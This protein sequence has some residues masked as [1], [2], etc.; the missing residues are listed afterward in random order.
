MFKESKLVI[1]DAKNGKD[2]TTDDLVSH[3]KQ[4]PAVEKVQSFGAF[5]RCM[6]YLVKFRPPIHYNQVFR[7]FEPNSFL[8][9]DFPIVFE[10]NPSHYDDFVQLQFFLPLSSN[11]LYCR[12]KDLTRPLGAFEIKMLNLL[13]IHQAK[14]RVCGPSLEILTDCVDTYRKF[15]KRDIELF[16]K[17]HLFG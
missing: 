9:G 5:N 7:E 16:H 14:V 11:K 17:A 3:Y 2:I 13:I 4:I 15:N 12:R 8:I 10:R 1:K 6:E